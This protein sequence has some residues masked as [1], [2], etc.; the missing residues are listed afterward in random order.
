MLFL[1]LAC[2]PEKAPAEKEPV[3]VVLTPSSSGLTTNA[4]AAIS[5]APDWIG[6]VLGLGLAF[7]G[8]GGLHL[9]A[10]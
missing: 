5:L 2:T 9:D 4:E 1:L 10:G 6:I 3:P 8:S 7:W